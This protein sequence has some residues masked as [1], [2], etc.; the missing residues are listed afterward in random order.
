MKKPINYPVIL[1]ILFICNSSCKKTGN[2]A[3]V[4]Q[5]TYEFKGK[6]YDCSDG[7]CG[8][9]T[10]GTNITG[11]SIYR[12]DLWGGNI[13]FKYRYCSYLDPGLIK[14]NPG[15]M[16]TNFDGTAIDSSK[17]YLYQSGTL[18]STSS[19]CTTKTISDIYTGLSKT[20]SICDIQGNFSLT[21]VNNLGDKIE[22]TNGIFSGRLQFE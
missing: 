14:L 6:I 22:I 1:F 4:N 17:V 9:F 10:D 20:V 8:F 21:L 13:I 2:A 5:F 7:N 19:N 12:Y 18:N 11:I 15:C 3:I 16:L